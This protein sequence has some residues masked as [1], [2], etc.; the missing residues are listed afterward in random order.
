M[1]NLI[2]YMSTSIISTEQ[3]I[4]DKQ[5]RCDAIETENEKDNA[6]AQKAIEEAVAALGSVG[7]SVDANGGTSVKGGST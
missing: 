1:M 3:Q 7:T 2:L 4:K 5:A 6:K